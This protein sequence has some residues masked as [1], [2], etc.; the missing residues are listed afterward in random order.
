MEFSYQKLEKP[1]TELNYS[2]NLYSLIGSALSRAH[3]TGSFTED[4]VDYYL[5]DVLQ[6]GVDYRVGDYGVNVGYNQY[7]GNEPV[8]YKVGVSFPFNIEGM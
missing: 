8:Q 2:H 5:N 7:V 6:L 4:D 3:E 1:K